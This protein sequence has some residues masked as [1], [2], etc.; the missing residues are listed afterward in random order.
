MIVDG[1]PYPFEIY[2]PNSL[3]T[4][5]TIDDL[6]LGDLIDIYYFERRNTRE[7]GLNRFVQFIDRDGHP[8]FIRSS[9]QKHLGYL[10]LGLCSFVVLGAWLFFK[11]KKLPW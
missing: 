9:F 4:E 8:Y 3:T 11:Y 5:M 7:I 1:Y 2:E 6:R 10:L